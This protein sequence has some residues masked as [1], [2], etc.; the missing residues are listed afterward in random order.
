MKY[1]LTTEEKR[2]LA[3]YIRQQA[4]ASEILAE[5]LHQRANE[6]DAECLLESEAKP[7]VAEDGK[8]H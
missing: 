7:T 6:L 4:H 8:E 5:A 1:N 3:E 2:R